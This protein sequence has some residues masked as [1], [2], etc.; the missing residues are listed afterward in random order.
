MS[1]QSAA[2]TT[3]RSAPARSARAAVWHTC[4]S[5][6]TANPFVTPARSRSIPSIRSGTFAQ[7]S[8]D[9]VAIRSHC[10]LVDSSMRENVLRSTVRSVVVSIAR[11]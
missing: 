8:I 1:W 7:S 4:V 6:S 9:S 3:S 2:A 11:S 10:S 5:W